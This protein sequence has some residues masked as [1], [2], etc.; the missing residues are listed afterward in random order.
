MKT[1]KYIKTIIF[2]LCLTL[3]LSVY[4]TYF[5]S[6]NSLLWNVSDALFGTALVLLV[7][8]LLQFSFNKGGFASFRYAY[9]KHKAKKNKQPIGEYHEFLTRD[10]KQDNSHLFIVSIV[11]IVLSIVLAYI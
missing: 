4:N 10:Q 11:L 9:Q 3:I 6:Y 8:G 2:T 5:K 7:V 1:N